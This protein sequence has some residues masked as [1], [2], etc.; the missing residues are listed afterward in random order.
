MNVGTLAD[1]EVNEGIDRLVAEIDRAVGMIGQLRHETAELKQ[2]RQALQSD[3]AR[4]EGELSEVRADRER[5]QRIYDEN[6]SLIEN[7]AQIRT[8]IETML[9]RLDALNQESAGA[10]SQA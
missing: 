4:L 8:K 5:L 7:K 10:N 6:V 9:S 2:Q 3:I 1:G